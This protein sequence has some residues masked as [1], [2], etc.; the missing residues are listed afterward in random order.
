MGEMT[1]ASR[2]GSVCVCVNKVL[3]TLS[4]DVGRRPGPPR[5]WKVPADLRGVVVSSSGSS[6]SEFA[7]LHCK[8]VLIIRVGIVPN[9]GVTLQSSV[10]LL[11]SLKALLT[12]SWF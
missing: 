9:G 6:A 3:E 8:R 7:L 10:L 12:D 4:G 1:A 5:I 2:D 11:E